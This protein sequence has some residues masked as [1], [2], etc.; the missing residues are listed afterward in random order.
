MKLTCSCGNTVYD[1]TDS[2]PHKGHIVPDEDLFSNFDSCDSILDRVAAKG[3]VDESDYM[4]LR[5]LWS[6]ARPIY[7]CRECGRV[8]IWE[9]SVQGVFSFT[10]DDQG[11]PNDL[12]R[13]RRTVE[14]G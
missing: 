5:S 8:L 4:D 10:P 13:S 1:G 3:C 2:L 6:S 9:K 12:L 11:N 14:G 7:Q